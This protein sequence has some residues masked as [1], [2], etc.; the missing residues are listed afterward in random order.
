M[1]L[2]EALDEE[3]H[4]KKARE[5]RI[6]EVMKTLEASDRKALERALADETVK[7]PWIVRAL[8]KQGISVSIGAVRSYREAINVA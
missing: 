2:S 8:K 6:I 3:R 7:A 1:G 4:K 5:H